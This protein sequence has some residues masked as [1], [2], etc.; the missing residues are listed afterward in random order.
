MPSTRRGGTG[1]RD[2]CSLPEELIG[3]K[4][5]DNGSP[6]TWIPNAI[7]SAYSNSARQVESCGEKEYLV[8]LQSPVGAS[9]SLLPHRASQGQ[10]VSRDDLRR[11]LWGERHVRGFRSRPEFLHLRR[12]GR[13]LRMILE[14][15][16]IHYDSKS[17]DISSSLLPS[18]GFPSG[19]AG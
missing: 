2:V 14:P 3:P 15:V 1:A 10:V 11:T 4:S 5:C 18:N 8:R 12:F 17:T 7:D 9:R 19:R 16:Y 6:K 13:R